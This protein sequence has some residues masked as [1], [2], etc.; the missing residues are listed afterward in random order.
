M[1]VSPSAKYSSISGM[2]G[3]FVTN[4]LSA[5]RLAARAALRFSFTP[6]KWPIRFQF[7]LPDFVDLPDFR[8]LADALVSAVGFGI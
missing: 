3:M 5:V 2:D 7:D 6:A 8:G 4:V 1:S